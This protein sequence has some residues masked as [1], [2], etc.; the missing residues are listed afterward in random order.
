[1]RA[2]KFPPDLLERL[3]AKI[4]VQDDRLLLGAKVG[5]DAAVLDFGDRVLVA[6]TDPVTFATHHIGWYAVQV[7]A[8]D[9]ACAGAT[10]RWFMATILVPE[11]FGQDDAEGIFD[12]VLEAC[13]ALGVT[14][15]GGHSEVTRGLQ[16]PIVAGC[17]L[18]EAEK[19]KI[20]PTSGAKDGDSIV[21]TKGIAIEGTSLLAYDAEDAL[22]DASVA[23]ETIAR[24]KELLFSGISVVKEA[25]T[26]CAS[27]R[28]N[29]LH[30]PT[31]GGLATGLWEV[32]KAAGVGL[33]VEEGS[34][35]VLPECDEI[36]RALD[37]N[38]LGL[39]ASGSLLITLPP[40][41]VPRLLS[42]LEGEGIDGFEIGR[43]TG[44]E[45]GVKI[46]GSSHEPDPLPSFERDELARFFRP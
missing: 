16:H 33:A 8:N 3:L 24:S 45:E 30:D 32:A 43:I 21:V 5:E 19:G 23:A 42:T 6:K 37:L 39:L 20:V 1:M 27:V 29:S 22:R 28:V 14:L 35:P 17:M 34:I 36:C 4:D 25:L 13:G 15:V 38:P 46:I 12:Q 11:G 44:P 41:D 10:P 2:G 40:E 18:G 26:A 7:N 9:V 31:E